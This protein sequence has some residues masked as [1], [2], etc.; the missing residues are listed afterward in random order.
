MTCERLLS[1]EVLRSIEW[2]LK[3]FSHSW[4]SLLA[5]AG[6]YLERK[7]VNRFEPIKSLCQDSF[8]ISLGAVMGL[9]RSLAR[10][11]DAPMQGG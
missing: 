7:P 5:L 2:G 6:G 10:R 4:P 8:V 11:G 3:E 9:A 1:S